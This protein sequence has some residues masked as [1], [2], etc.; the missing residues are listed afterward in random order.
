M[1]LVFEVRRVR[2]MGELTVAM[3]R[4]GV[5]MVRGQ[6]SDDERAHEAEDALHRDVLQAIADGRCVDPSACAAA[7][8]ET[9]AIKFARWCA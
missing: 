1:T 3:V 7:A 4:A 5:D 9:R 2:G 8:L 6:S